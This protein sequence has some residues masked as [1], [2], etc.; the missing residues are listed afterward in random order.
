VG[1]GTGSSAS[2]VGGVPA[3]EYGSYLVRLRERIQ[4]SLNYPL[5]ARRRG[6]SGT[7]SLEI[8][9]KPD[10]AIGAVSVADTSSHPILDSAA[11]EAVR[12]LAPEPLP[13][14]V[15]PRTLRVRLPVVF[16]LERP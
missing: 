9:I 1:D 16:A 4:G 3:A 10:G 13:N 6:L 7:V 5:R 12:R 8:E 2:G 11:L 15:P 14:G